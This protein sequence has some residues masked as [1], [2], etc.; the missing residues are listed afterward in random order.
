MK[1]AI[2]GTGYVGLVAGVCLAQLGHDIISLDTDADKINQLKQGKIPIYETGLA[3]ILQQNSHKIT[4]TTDYKLAIP[5]AEAIFIAVGTPPRPDGQADLRYVE[6]AVKTLAQYLG[7]GRLRVIINKSTVPIGTKNMV[8]NAIMNANPQLQVGVDFAV[9]SNPEFLREGKA[10]EDFMRPDRIVVGC[11]NHQNPHNPVRM[12][13]EEIYRPLTSDGYPLMICDSQ[14]AELIKYAGN[15]FLAMKIGFIN[16]MADICEKIGADIE[17][18]AQGIGLDRRIGKDF[19]KAGPGYGGSCFPKDTTSLY[20]QSKLAGAPTSLIQ[21]VIESN[22]KRRNNLAQW[23]LQKLQLPHFG[24]LRIAL[25][26]LAFKGE[27]DDLRESPALNLADQLLAMQANFTAFDPAGMD[28]ARKLNPNYSLSD[29]LAECLKGAD[30]AII[31]TEWRQF[32][33]ITPEFCQKTMRGKTIID[34][35]NIINRNEFIKAGFTHYG[36][37]H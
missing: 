30:L 8:Q 17:L 37:G 13:M 28:H 23:I 7:D 9:V 15:G 29:N 26:G 32:A 20:E 24:G 27:T 35:R 31:A 12:V 16:E 1:I 10:V 22:H 11:D 5:P 19:L 34:L 21:A 33:T 6:S 18:L 4:F 2:I 3:E 14:T 36:I 25:L